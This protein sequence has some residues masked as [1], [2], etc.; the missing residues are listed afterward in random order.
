MIDSLSLWIWGIVALNL[1]V[2]V[3][4]MCALRYGS[5]MLF[6]V[7]SRD[8]L[9]EKDNLA[10]GLALAGGASAVALVLAAATAGDPAVTFQRELGVVAAYAAVGL[11]LLKV[12]ILVNDW[13][14]FH[15]FSVKAAIKAQNVAAGTVQAANLIALGILI[16][17]AIGWADGGL[18]QSLVSVAVMFFL[19]QFVVLGVTRTRAAIYARHHDGEQWQAAIE[20]GNTALGV[21]YAGHLIGT[22]L[23]SSSAGGMVAFVAGADSGALIAYGAWFVWAVVLAVALLLL[24]MLAQRVILHGVDVVEEVDRQRNIGVAAIE[25]AVFVGIGLVFRGAVAG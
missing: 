12:G 8:E 25:A 15:D 4:A 24:S 1:A 18:G 6:D 11:A 10:F 9:A 23:A 5:G 22:A 17:G 13:I 19:A 2:A 20:G 16:N 14:V 3:A 21:R 7:D